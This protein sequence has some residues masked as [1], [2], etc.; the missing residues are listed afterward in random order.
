MLE[1]I[2]RLAALVR[3]EMFAGVPRGDRD[4]F[5]RV[6][7]AAHANLSAFERKAS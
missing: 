6:L 3:T 7:E 1:E 5:M 4:G 2:W